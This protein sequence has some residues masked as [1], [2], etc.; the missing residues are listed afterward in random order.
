MLQKKIL[1]KILFMKKSK[2][3]QKAHLV[4]SFVT[5][6]SFEYDC[7]QKIKNAISIHY[8]P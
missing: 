4:E 1:Q 8:S 5:V 6:G 2:C 7:T 3:P